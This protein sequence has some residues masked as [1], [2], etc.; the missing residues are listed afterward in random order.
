M[1]YIVYHNIVSY[2]ISYITSH[3]PAPSSRPSFALPGSEFGVDRRKGA[4]Y[5]CVYIYIYIYTYVS[6]C[7]YAY[8][9]MC[10]F[11][12]IYIYRERER[13]TLTGATFGTTKREARQETRNSQ[14]KPTS[15]TY[16]P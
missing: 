13:E 7:V 11:T 12:Y 14:T 2:H 4:I 5:V 3:R 1:P 16:G 6:L 9:Y 15:E 8:V 10:A